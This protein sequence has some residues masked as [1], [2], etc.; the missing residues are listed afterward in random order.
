MRTTERVHNGL[1]TV[2]YWQRSFGGRRESGSLPPACDV[3]IIGGGVCGVSLALELE[4]GGRQAVVLERGAIGSGASSKNAGFLMRGA[5]D[6]YARAVEMYGRA[7]ARLVWRLSEENLAVLREDGVGGLATYRDVPSCLVAI[8][9]AEA[10]ELRRSHDLLV[11]DGFASALVE[12]GA[13]ALWSSGAAIVALSNPGDAS[14]N[15][16]ELMAHLTSRLATEPV[17][18]CEVAGLEVAGGRVTL[19]TSRGTM[20]ASR[21][22][23]CA[24]AFSPG[25]LPRLASAIQPNRGQMLAIEGAGLELHAS[26]YVNRGHEYLRQTPDGTIV[27]GGMRGRFVQEE[28]TSEDETTGELQAALEVFAADVLGRN[29]GSLRVTDRWAGTMGFTEDGLPIIG[30]VDPDAIVW[31]CAGFNG[32][33]M[34]LA[35]CCAR[36]CAREMLG[37]DASPFPLSRILEPATLE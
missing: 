23:V 4:Q 25:V 30:A 11:E 20:G 33:G 18:R 6:N 34:S 9:E 3:A 12:S 1:M 31:V 19:H 7:R 17:E 27:V 26:Y 35:R 5:A 28:R 13:D 37:G 36:A 24:N 16:C 14:C 2:S 8:D 15:P 10:E 32:H 21:V 29:A 22:V